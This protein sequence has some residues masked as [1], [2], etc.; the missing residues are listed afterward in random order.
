MSELDIPDVALMDNTSQRLPCVL[1]LDGS[2]SMDGEP[3]NELNAGLR[4]LEEELKKDDIASQRVQLLVI[5]FGGENVEVL[6]DWTD[7]MDFTAPNVTASGRTPMGQAVR[8]GLAKLE[9]QKTRYRANGVPYNRPWVFL[10]TDGGP[11][12]TG[13]PTAASECL[14]AEQMGKFVFFGIGVGPDADLS[15]LQQFSTRAPV[16]MQGIKFREMFVW[17]SKSTS[18]ASKAA[19]G[20]KVQLA[21]PTDWGDISA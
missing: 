17:L 12:D 7:A 11:T 13:W 15:T 1:L 9:E 2:G 3:I 8:T 21:P 18:S 10:I 19:P 5:R 4:I 14:A 20:A 6:T 16:R